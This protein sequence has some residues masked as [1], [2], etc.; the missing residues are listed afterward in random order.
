MIATTLPAPDTAR[1]AA[2][3]ALQQLLPHSSPSASTPSKRTG[4]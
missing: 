1:L 4:T 2:V 3:S